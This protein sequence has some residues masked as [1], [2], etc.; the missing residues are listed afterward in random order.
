MSEHRRRPAAFRL[1][2]PNVVVKAEAGRTPRGTVKIMVEPE[3]ELPA[4]I[5]P[6]PLPR[7]GF[8][9]STLFWSACGA[10]AALGIAVSVIRLIE[11]LFS[12]NEALGWL[13]A[14]LAA[15]AGLAFMAIVLREASGLWRLRNIETLRRRRAAAP[16]RDHP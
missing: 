15:F 9:W 13:G 5:E 10:L 12:R 8:A 11:D 1:D 7:R 3:P 4:T 14:A 16:A 6:D 2:D